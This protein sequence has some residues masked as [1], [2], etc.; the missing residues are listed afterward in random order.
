[1]RRRGVVSLAS[2]SIKLRRAIPPMKKLLLALSLSI[3]LG[4]ALHV[5]DATAAVQSVD[6]VVAVVD[7]DVITNNE[8]EKRLQSIR[9]QLAR[10]NTPPP[11]EGLLRRQ[12][13]EHMIVERLQLTRAQ[14]I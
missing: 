4:I 9:K 10:S 7:D 8:L 11:P 1:M 3:N 14:R 6:K 12:M 2:L 13:L 5:Q